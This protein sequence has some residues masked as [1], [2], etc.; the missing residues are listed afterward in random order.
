MNRLAFLEILVEIHPRSYFMYVDTSLPHCVKF[1]STMP[2]T[3]TRS[4]RVGLEQYY[5][6]F[7]TGTTGLG[8]GTTALRKIHRCCLL[9]SYAFHFQGLCT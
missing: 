6:S 2:W 7:F 4:E 9:V 5:R 1:C 3:E 8:S